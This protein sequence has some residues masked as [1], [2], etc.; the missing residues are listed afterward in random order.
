MLPLVSLACALPRHAAAIR[1]TQLSDVLALAMPAQ[2]LRVSRLC[3][4]N[5][6]YRCAQVQPFQLVP[7]APLDLVI[8]QCAASRFG[9]QSAPRLSAIY[10]RC[11]ELGY[12]SDALTASHTL[13]APS[14]SADVLQRV[15]VLHR[16][17]RRSLRHS[18]ASRVI[19][20]AHFDTLRS[21]Y[22]SSPFPIPSYFL[23]LRQL[24]SIFN[25]PMCSI[26]LDCEMS[27]SNWACFAT[28]A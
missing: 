15:Q 3:L 12:T 26:H 18:I 6:A 21:N 4:N 22:W 7:P 23:P 19:F 1:R 16:S 13:H 14:Q 8:S 24:N 27:Q 20:A 11:A 28:I 9:M 2:Q 5:S 25:T 17:R 10:Q